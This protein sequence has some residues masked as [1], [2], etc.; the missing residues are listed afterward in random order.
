MPWAGR[1]PVCHY[2]SQSTSLSLRIA[3]ADSGGSSPP[4]RKTDFRENQP[5][6]GPFWAP[7]PTPAPLRT[8]PCSSPFAAPAPDDQHFITWRHLPEWGSQ[9]GSC[10]EATI[11]E[12]PAGPPPGHKDP[13]ALLCRSPGRGNT[14]LVPS[15]SFVWL[16][17][18]S[19]TQSSER[20]TPEGLPGREN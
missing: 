12:W 4:G 15:Q 5:A 20:P 2:N 1:P 9:G 11:C 14:Q 3:K 16:V 7:P 18:R 6:P 17:L 13:R 8:R 19:P 10:G